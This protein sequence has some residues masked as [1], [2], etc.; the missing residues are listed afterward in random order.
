M[1]SSQV[2]CAKM[3]HVVAYSDNLRLFCNSSYFATLHHRL[4]AVVM[5]VND[6]LRTS[7]GLIPALTSCASKLLTR[8]VK[9]SAHAA[10]QLP[11]SSI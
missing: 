7:L 9:A 3:D 4:V 1:R 5:L 6:Q 2:E 10:A 8:R 11:R